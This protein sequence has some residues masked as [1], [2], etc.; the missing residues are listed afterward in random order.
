M[1]HPSDANNGKKYRPIKISDL[2]DLPTDIDRLAQEILSLGG[3]HGQRRRSLSGGEKVVRD[4]EGMRARS[5]SRGSMGDMAPMVLPRTGS[6]SG[7]GDL[8]TYYEGV[9]S[10]GNVDARPLTHR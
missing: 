2:S 8:D 7:E 9:A 1:S 5:T 6:L 4:G 3:G 10:T